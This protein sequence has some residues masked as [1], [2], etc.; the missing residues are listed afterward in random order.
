MSHTS[1]VTPSVDRRLT[2]TSP[3]AVHTY[4][5][6]MKT[7]VSKHDILS[8][9]QQLQKV[10]E[11][12]KWSD[13]RV[14]VWE[15]IDKLLSEARIASKRKCKAKRSGLFPWSP[16]LQEAGCRLLYWK[17]R[18]SAH[19]CNKVNANTLT[20]LTTQL[21]V[22]PTDQ[23]PQLG[24]TIRNNIQRSRRAFT[25][26]KVKAQSLREEH[27]RESASFFAATQQMLEK[28]AAA[29]IA[30]RERS[31][32][33]FRHLRSIFHKGA[34]YGL[35]RID[36][37]D[38]YAVLRQNEETPR[39]PLVV[40]EAIEEVLVPHT[41]RRFRQHQETPFGAGKRQQ[42]LGIDCTSNDARD[43][44]DGTYDREL[45]QLTE[46]ARTWLTALRTRDF[47]TAGA[48]IDTT[49]STDD[50]ICGWKKMR[51]ST[52][53][54]PGGHY[55]HYKTAA[56]V[57]K[58][59]NKHRDYWPVLSE[60]YAIMATL[61]LKHGF[62]PTRWQKCINAILEKIP[63]QPR[64]EK[65]RIIMLYEADFN[66]V[67]KLIW[68]RRLVRHAELHQCLGDENHGS[69][70]GRQS[71][72]AQLQ[73][74]LLYKYAQLTRTSLITLDNDT[75]SC[76]DRIIKPLAMIACIAVGLPLL[77]AAMHNRTHYGMQD[78]IRTRHGTLQPYA[79]TN[80]EVLE[81]TGQGSGASPAIWLIYS[82]SLLRAFQQFTPGMMVS[83]PFA[84]L[85]VTILAI[86]YV[87]D[88]MPGVNDSQEA[89]A[90]PLALL[91]KQAEDATQ[92]WE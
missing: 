53:S 81:G 6:A 55:G 17:L 24:I 18:M 88:G 3:R 85:I 64:I 8:K 60:I 45:E 37:P 50:W 83:S 32:Q 56:V 33:Q 11:T 29:A 2:S 1:E 20:K 43:L 78:S 49:I 10:S 46:E 38:S 47:V 63:G 66:F 69:R 52:A 12:G 57:A 35:D 72:D 73:K 62:A 26:A 61:P 41:E 21:K 42:E 82:M 25:K 15:S 7:Q 70:S 86:S 92:S 65:L 84:S 23:G 22:S 4:I 48:V 79:G 13:E 34:S 91:L 59:P 71:T 39:I 74:L 51:E 90:L 5:E 9:V 19:M 67:L 30:A 87:D 36:V 89:S 40:K 16:A 58:L 54:A 14:R 31:L 75:K 28:A 27:L 44:M 76:Y 80:D 77:A 68:G